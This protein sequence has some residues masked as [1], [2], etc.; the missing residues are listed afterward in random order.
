[1][2][3]GWCARALKMRFAILG[4]QHCAMSYL[5]LA[6]LHFQLCHYDDAL[7]LYAQA[8]ECHALAAHGG[9]VEGEMLDVAAA[10]SEMALIYEIKGQFDKAWELTLRAADRRRAQDGGKRGEA[11]HQSQVDNMILSIQTR[12]RARKRLHGVLRALRHGHRDYD[13]ELW[14][15][16]KSVTACNVCGRGFS[17]LRRRHHCR[18]CGHVICDK[19]SHTP[20]GKR[21]CSACR[22]GGA[23]GLNRRSSPE[24]PHD[25]FG[26]GTWA[27]GLGAGGDAG[28]EAW[29]GGEG[30]VGCRAVSLNA[31]P[32]LPRRQ[33]GEGRGAREED[34]E[35][36]VRQWLITRPE[37]PVSAEQLPRPGRARGGSPKLTIP[38]FTAENFTTF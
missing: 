22:D 15:P 20:R 38:D 23:N 19:C 7:P 34:A 25:S 36:S 2:A 32:V 9:Q 37:R 11:A 26:I 31:T 1:M 16:D 35:G 28:Q 13:A 5:T 3:L 4:A 24:R 21:I 29:D 10:F 12:L 18:M 33:G 17:L 8:V 6:Q 14:V 30:G 27:G